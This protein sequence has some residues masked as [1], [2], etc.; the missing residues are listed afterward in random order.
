MARLTDPIQIVLRPTQ[1]QR[2]KWVHAA[3]TRDEDLRTF[4]TWCLDYMARYVSEVYTQALHRKWDPM[5]LRLEE[6]KR[7]RAVV[8]A[9]WHA[10]DF[11]PPPSDSPVSGAIRDPKGDLRKALDALAQYLGDIQEE[12]LK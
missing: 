2:A 8:D 9:A 6:K 12:Y 1:T 3:L 11:L 4:I 10:L 5:L 7:L